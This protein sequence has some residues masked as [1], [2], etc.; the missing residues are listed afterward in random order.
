MKGTTKAYIYICWKAMSRTWKSIDKANMIFNQHYSTVITF[1]C[2]CL[3]SS[4]FHFNHN[5]FVYYGALSYNLL[6]I[7]FQN[8][9]QEE[10]TLS[11]IWHKKDFILYQLKGYMLKNPNVIIFIWSYLELKLPLPLTYIFQIFC[12]KSIR[13]IHLPSHKLQLDVYCL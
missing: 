6:Y 4:N 9:S 12:L 10:T 7:S 2:V 8:C 1:I 13:L 11:V 3:F 5:Y